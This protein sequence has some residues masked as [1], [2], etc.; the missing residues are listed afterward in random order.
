MR[1]LIPNRFALI[2]A[3][4]VAAL[5]AT[6][7]EGQAKPPQLK[8]TADLRIDTALA[9]PT[10]YAVILPMSSG[11]M[12][13][14]PQEAQGAI[15]WFDASGRALP[16]KAAVGFAKDPDIRWV[17]RMGWS[18]STLVAIDPGFRQIALLDR[19]G[20]VTKSLEYPSVIRPSWADRHKYPIFTRYE[21][22]ALYPNGE[23][24]VRAAE[25]K[26]F[27]STAEYDSS[28]TYFM[29]TNE[30]GSIQRTIARVPKNEG[31]IDKRMGQ[32][33]FMYRVPFVPR[34]LWDVSADGSRLVI[35]TQGVRGADSATYRATVLGENGDTIF[36]KK[37]SATLSAVSKKSVDSALARIRGGRDLPVED[38][39]A[40]VAKQI[41][42]VFPPVDNLIVGVDKT[43]WLELHSGAADRQW[44]AIDPAGVP[45]GVASVARTFVARAGDR[46]H[47]WGFEAEGEQLRT[48]VRYTVSSTPTKR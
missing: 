37:Y 35:V 23:W 14:S 13:V 45:I 11:E 47:L 15:R 33:R 10:R 27:M 43:I 46:T 24:L 39:R 8:A 29:R 25:A 1:A 2:A 3:T 32:S 4:L 20:K 48:L 38:L 7:V 19:A 30:N 44:L 12:I 16:F 42:P 40:F 18:G 22:Y 17:T 21:T 5:V 6:R 26:T 41:P 9:T 31:L 28:Y 36:S 34:T